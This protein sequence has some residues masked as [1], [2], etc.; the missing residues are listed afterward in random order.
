VARRRGGR[1]DVWVSWNGATTIRRWRVVA[2]GRP[3][4]TVPFADLEA[5]A[6]VRTSA[7]AVTVEALDAGDA[8]L[9]SSDLT[10]VRSAQS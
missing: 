8:V 9:G 3:V 5:K 1:V 2:G 7:T 6:T 10:A 4:A